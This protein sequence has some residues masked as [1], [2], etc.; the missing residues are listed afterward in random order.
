[1]EPSLQQAAPL[2]TQPVQPAPTPKVG[3]F[4]RGWLLTKSSWHVWRLDKELTSLPLISFLV[5]LI[6]LIPVGL[7]VFATTDLQSSKQLTEQTGEV[8]YQSSLTGWEQGLI[9]FGVA[10]ITTIIANFFSGA[11]IYGAT[12][13]FRGGDP[14]VRTSIAGA[15][16]KFRPLALFSLMMVTVGLVL[17]FLEERLPFA[18]RIAAYLF[19]AAWNIA[20]VFAIPVIVLSET[21]VNP[22]QATK[23]SVQVIKKVW[24]EGIVVS[25]GIGIIAAITYFVYA[26]TFIVAGSVVFGL[27][28]GVSTVPLYAIGAVGILGFVALILVFSTL[29]AIVK[30][31][32]YQYAITGQA[33]GSFDK[34]LLRS[35]MTPKKASKI[36]K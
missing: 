15:A 11:V 12:Q 35:S 23:Q 8:V 1:M 4:K 2:P 6:V 10:L 31:A 20:N 25:L 7:L 16:H 17:Q 5:S 18:G 30:A 9:V 24:G 21:N 29:S 13:R 22:I 19:D 32:L 33:P 14:T 36:F 34:E 3:A 27:S 28:G 26:L